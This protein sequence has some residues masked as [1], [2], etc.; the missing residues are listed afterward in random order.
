[1]LRYSKATLKMDGF[2]NGVPSG[3]SSTGDRLA[4]WESGRS[5]IFTFGKSTSTKLGSG[6]S[7]PG[8]WDEIRLWNIARTDNDIM[9]TY[10]RKFSP[11]GTNLVAYWR[12]D[13]RSM[14]VTDSRGSS[15]RGQIVGTSQLSYRVFRFRFCSRRCASPPTAR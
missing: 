6:Q 3:T 1:V 12:F 14:A 8:E 2:V 10:D 13:Y 15:N 7:L 9:S 11:T 4:G 5:I